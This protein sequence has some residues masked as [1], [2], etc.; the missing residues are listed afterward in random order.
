MTRASDTTDS[1]PPAADPGGAVVVVLGS[2]NTDLVVA[3][4]ALPGPGETTVG[5]VFERHHGGKGG[6]QAV[7]AAR[8]FR[9]APGASPQQGAGRV[10]MLGAVGADDLGT[11]ALAAL[12]R[13]GVDCDRVA[14]RADVATGVALIAVDAAGRNQIS[15]AAGA[16]A[17]LDPDDV[18]AA[19]RAVFAVAPGRSHD[20]PAAGRVLLASLEIPIP[21]VVAAG[22]AARAAGALFVLNPAPAQDVPP[23]LVRLAHVVTPN[24]HE[25]GRLGPGWPGPPEDAARRLAAAYPLVTF[26]VTL[27]ARGVF[28][29]GPGISGPVRPIDVRVVD[30]T[31]AGD[32]FNGALAAALAEGAAVEAAI[33]RGRTAGGLATTRIGAREAMPF[34]DEIDRYERAEERRGRDVSPPGEP[35]EVGR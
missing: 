12:R 35:E 16:N 20:D 28:T 3:G 14:V 8:A 24:E 34:R 33:R 4:A 2:I 6:N 30:T 9:V 7:A 27:G 32:T 22:R 13:D 25:I 26:A 19:V 1:V 18:E 10:V 17:T 5:G 31:G 21:A 15:V 23:E 11:E 29:T